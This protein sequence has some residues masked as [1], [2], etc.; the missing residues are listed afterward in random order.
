M[1][2]PLLQSFN[3]N[4]A[5]VSGLKHCDKKGYFILAGKERS[6]DKRYPQKSTV[7]SSVS[8][9]T[10]GARQVLQQS[11]RLQAFCQKGLFLV[12]AWADMTVKWMNKADLP[13][14]KLLRKKR[15]RGHVNTLRT[16]NPHWHLAPKYKRFQSRR[17]SD[18]TQTWCWNLAGSRALT[19][20]TLPYLRKKK[21]K[22]KTKRK[23]RVGP[24]KITVRKLKGQCHDIQWFFCA[25]LPE[26]K[27][28]TAHASV[29][30]IT[31]WQ[32]GQPRAQLH[33]P[34]CVEK[35]SFSS[36]N[37]RFPRPCLVAAIIFSHTKWL[38]KITDYRDTAAL[39][40]N[41]LIK[42]TVLDKLHFSCRSTLEIRW[43]TCEQSEEDT[44][45]TS[46]CSSLGWGVSARDYHHR[47]RLTM[48][49]LVVRLSLL[50]GVFKAKFPR[51]MKID[52]CKH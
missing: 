18:V 22:E 23:N 17:Q 5:L 3:L 43:K 21:K 44:Q 19:G 10:T 33:P 28:A 40:R 24:G 38:P 50:L 14:P 15:Q 34:S 47:Q 49:T 41:G 11:F 31:P 39:T 51:A 4:K 12:H 45:K 25:F 48:C 42:W 37:C 32:L 26:E 20:T 7:Q 27:M 9:L 1:Q 35:M 8:R 52:F 16:Y 6:K 30:D 13:N 2:L 29:A 46:T 36:S